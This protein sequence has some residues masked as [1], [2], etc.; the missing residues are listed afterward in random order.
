MWFP[1]NTSADLQSHW[2]KATQQLCSPPVKT[3]SSQTT[4]TVH[5]VLPG[6]WWGNSHWDNYTCSSALLFQ[7]GLLGECSAWCSGLPPVW[8]P[9]TGD[10]E[11]E[12][13]RERDGYIEKVRDERQREHETLPDIG[14]MSCMDYN[15]ISTGTS[16]SKFGIYAVMQL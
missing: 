9:F 4:Y 1:L 2:T 14:C 10:R 12:G 8:K 7:T 16:F 15:L 6:N 3:G 13:R 11:T 5:I